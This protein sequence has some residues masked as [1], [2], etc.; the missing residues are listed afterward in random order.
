MHTSSIDEA[1]HAGYAQVRQCCPRALCCED[2]LFT[3]AQHTSTY[4]G[5]SCPLKRCISNHAPYN[6]MICSRDKSLYRPS[7]N[8]DLLSD[9]DCAPP[10]KSLPH[11]EGDAGAGH[12]MHKSRRSGPKWSLGCHQ[13]N[14][15]A[16]S[17][18]HCIGFPSAVQDFGQSLGTVFNLNGGVHVTPFT[19]RLF[20]S[21]DLF[22]QC[23][24]KGKV[25]QGILLTSLS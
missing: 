14:T 15:Q 4:H 24:P 25:L 12:R 8:F 20:S 19:F 6:G 22:P 18:V 2:N 16:E 13:P 1:I 17:R 3:H 7:C 9:A 21:V 5:G 10:C 23:C 11:H